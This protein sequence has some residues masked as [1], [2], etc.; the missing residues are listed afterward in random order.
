MK[1]LLALILLISWQSLT[2]AGPEEAGW[3]RG[4]SLDRSTAQCSNLP[5]WVLRVAQSV[6]LPM[7]YE[8]SHHLNPFFQSGDFD[9]D[10]KLDVA[11]LVR[12][13]T[14]G[15]IGI[16]I[17][18]YGRTKPVVLGAGNSFGNGGTDFSWVDN[19]SVYPKDEVR[20]SHWEDKPPAP[21][22]DALWVAKSESAS[23]FIFWDG[24]KYVWYQESD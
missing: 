17:F 3:C 5:D 24:K 20:K 19:W 14:T 11:V 8:L 16:A 13:K 7:H 4:A 1:R 9:A 2:L 12:H 6:K 10:R 21:K 15:R 22:G 23:A 18:L